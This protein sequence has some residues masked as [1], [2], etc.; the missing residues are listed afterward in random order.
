MKRTL[1]A[2]ALTAA[3]AAAPFAASN[4]LAADQYKFDASHSQILF[5]YNHLGFSTTYGLI[6]GFD[7][8]AVIDAENLANSSVKIELSVKDLL[9]TGWEARDTHFKSPDFFDAEANPAATFVSKSVEPTGDKTAKVTGDLT[10]AGQTKEV[11]LDVT[12]NQVGKNPLNQKDWAGF[13]ATTTL[14]RSDF[15]LGKFAPAVSDEVELKIS[16]EMEKTGSV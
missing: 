15:G 4:A 13:D 14:K 2:L 8:E 1:Q 7:G 10:I 6:S 5:S 11:V 9:S 16:V 3:L 12:L